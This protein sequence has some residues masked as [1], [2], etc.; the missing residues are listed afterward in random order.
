MGCI[1]RASLLIW[2]LA[3]SIFLKFI[4][5]S[6]ARLPHRIFIIRHAEKPESGDS[7]HL[8]EKGR[9]R[10]AALP[11]YPLPPLADIFAAK[12]S[13]AC[14]RPVETVTP[15]AAAGR[16]NI[17]AEVDEE[18]FPRLVDDVLSGRFA[19]KDILICWHHEEIPHLTR[20]LGVNLTR[21]YRWPDVY[22]RIFVVTYLKDGTP[23][24]E[25]RPQRLL[26]GDSTA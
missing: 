4:L 22:D 19:G 21:S 18:E 20:S 26:P 3:Q 23:T 1:Q 11:R 10:A 8:S 16:L 12:T 25:D 14:A 15:L 7:P 9:R 5:M 17:N 13:P 24:F 2:T 6:P